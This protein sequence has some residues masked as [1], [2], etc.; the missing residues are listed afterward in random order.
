VEAALTELRV[1][2]INRSFLTGRIIVARLALVCIATASAFAQDVPPP[3][4]VFLPHQVVRVANLPSLTAPSANPAAVLA[5]SL[6]TILHDQDV[7][8]GKDSGLE[9]AVLSAPTSLKEL[10]ARLQGRHV[11]SDGLSITVRAECFPQSSV[12]AGRVISTLMDQQSML[13]EWK[14]RVYVLYGAIFDETRVYNPD[15]WQ[16]V[17]HK[18]FLLD[19]RFSDQRRETQFNNGTDDWKNVQGFLTVSVARP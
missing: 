7:C 6:E 17:I 16:F 3:A 2:Q 10:S 15:G 11:L 4:A 13:I 12:N 18:L 8:C 19:L 5:T 9:D 1:S 14:S